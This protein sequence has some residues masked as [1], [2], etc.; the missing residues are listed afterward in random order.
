MRTRFSDLR[1]AHSFGLGS[2]LLLLAMGS[3]WA[4]A[5]DG[6]AA[7]LADPQFVEPVQS[8]DYAELTP[9]ALR[10]SIQVV[11]AR[12]YAY[13]GFNNPEMLIHLP[14]VGNS[15]LARVEM[16]EPRLVDSSGGEVAYQLEPGLHDPETQ[17]AEIR[18]VTTDGESP[19]TFARAIGRISVRYPLVVETL[20]KHP[21][22]RV[23]GPYVDVD[24]GVLPE[25][26]PFAEIQPLR[27]YDAQGRQLKSELTG[28]T[29]VEGERVIRRLGFHGSVARVE[30]DQV[31]HWV[32]VEIS[33]DVPI[34]EP[35]PDPKRG[36]AGVDER[37]KKV[38]PRS[39]IEID[40]A[41]PTRRS[42]QARS[43]AEALAALREAL[44]ADPSIVSVNASPPTYAS[45][46][47]DSG[48]RVEE[49]TWNAGG[50][51]GPSPVVTDWLDCKKGMAPGA[52]DLES[53]PALMDKAAQRVGT[54][55]RPIQ[56]VVGQSPCGTPFIHIPFDGGRS[57][58]FD[59]KGEVISEN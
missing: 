21:G 16:P 41:D 18:F 24:D 27:A 39:R 6:R 46:A 59:G 45:I 33:Y 55:D 48:D 22:V 35:L 28:S 52:L 32:G 31:S 25:T 15:T 58:Q 30:I 23:N 36:F 51:S 57:V 42:A 9:D 34:A 38:D 20:S 37:A 4:S 56:I 47:V 2:L 54:G 29:R 43:L 14:L 10:G 53:L 50:V 7:L 3:S 19:A 26:A 17:I 44:P 11:A 1:P 12:T 40:I 5:D 8:P 13:Y 49:W